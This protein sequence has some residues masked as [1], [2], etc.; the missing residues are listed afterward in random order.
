MVPQQVQNILRHL[1]EVH[2]IEKHLVTEALLP[3]GTPPETDELLALRA[4]VEVE[5]KD[6]EI[7]ESQ[8]V[9]LYADALNK[10]PFVRPSG[11]NRPSVLYCC[12]GTY[13]LY[14]MNI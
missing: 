4:R 10:H 12:A 2:N 1:K 13:A 3:K 11:P 7:L 5:S 8:V 9:R 14:R 6:Y